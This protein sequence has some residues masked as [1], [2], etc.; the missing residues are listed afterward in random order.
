MGGL[1]I[2]SAPVD[3]ADHVGA[4]VDRVDPALISD[5]MGQAKCEIACAGADVRD[6][7]AGFY[8]QGG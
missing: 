7:F 8:I 4:D 3:V 6:Y 5:K 1:R 2:A